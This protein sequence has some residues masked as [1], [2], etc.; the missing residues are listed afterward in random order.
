MMSLMAELE[1]PT[2]PYP[3]LRDSSLTESSVA[4]GTIDGTQMRAILVSLK[5]TKW[6]GMV[7]MRLKTTHIRD[8]SRIVKNKEKGSTTTK[9]E[10]SSISANSATIVRSARERSSTTMIQSSR[11]SSTVSRRGRGLSLLKMVRAYR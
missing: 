5:T 6:K 4:T 8:S 7:G 1:R 3:F 10:N 11:A 2:T 9:R